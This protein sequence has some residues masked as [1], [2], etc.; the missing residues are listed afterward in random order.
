MMLLIFPLLMSCQTNSFDLDKLSFPI[1][2][3][4]IE[5]KYELSKNSDLSG[6]IVY[7]STDPALLQFS[8]FSFSGTLD[9]QDNSIL[10]TNYVSFYENR[11]TN[12]VNA[13]RLEIKTTSKA[14]EFEKLL[15]KKVGKTDF[16]YRDSEFSYRVW[17]RGN[18][19]YLFETNNTGKYNDEKFKS[20][21]L[22]V[23]ANGDQ[24]L[25]N[26]F[27]SGGFQYYGDYLQEKNKPEHKGKTYTY[28]NFVDEKEKDDGKDSFYL[29]DYVK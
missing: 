2:I 12:K 9:K 1:D 5:K 16:Y 19:L 26:Y 7:N 20:C 23:V 21:N 11:T 6:I 8:G 14:E 4:V 29:K 15:E 22:Y 24:L 13:Y 28:R 27:I 25:N 17:N 3:S 18:K 10:S